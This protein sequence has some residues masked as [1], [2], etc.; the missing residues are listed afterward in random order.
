MNSRCV[1]IRKV[2]LFFWAALVS[3]AGAL[4]L[5]VTI[6]RV[7]EGAVAGESSNVL[8]N[9]Q[10]SMVSEDGRY[11]VFVST[12]ANLFAGQNDN[13]SASDVFLFDRVTGTISLVSHLAGQPNTSVNGASFSPS[14]SADGNFVVFSTDATNFGA[15]DTN[16]K[17]DI[18]L[19]SRLSDTVQVCSH[20]G[21][22]VITAS[23]GNCP[24]PASV[25]GDGTFVLFACDGTNLG[26]TDT[27][28]QQDL[29]LFNS[30]TAALTLVSHKAGNST[31]AMDIGL[32]SVVSSISKD[33][34]YVAFDTTAT[35]LGFT[36]GGGVSY[37]VLYDRVGDSFQLVSRNSAS[38]TTIA[39]DDSYR[40]LV[41]DDGS[42][43]LFFSDG[44]DLGFTDSNAAADLFIFDRGAG[45]VQLASR[46]GVSATTTA[47]QGVDFAHAALSGDGNVAVFLTGSTDMGFSDGNGG[48][49]CVIFDRTVGT[50]GLASHS[51]LGNTFTANGVCI[52]TLSVNQD[53]SRVAFSCN[54]TNLGFTDSNGQRD[55]F[56]YA[57]ASHAVTLVSHKLGDSTTTANDDAQPANLCISA[58]GKFLAF[59]SVATDLVGG[60]NNGVQDVFLATLSAPSPVVA[61]GADVTEGLAP[62]DVQ[63]Q[64]TGTTTTD[65]SN[66]VTYH[67]DPG[68]GSGVTDVSAP[69]DTLDVTY[70][71]PGIYAAKLSVTTDAGATSDPMPLVIVAGNDEVGDVD[72]EVVSMKVT[73]DHAKAAQGVQNDKLTLSGRFNP[74]GLPDDVSLVDVALTVNDDDLDQLVLNST[75]PA[76]RI[77]KTL[78][79]TGQFK[80]AVGGIRL[81]PT[82]GRRS[83]D[84]G[85]E[86]RIVKVAVN[87]PGATTPDASTAIDTEFVSTPGKKASGGFSFAKRQ[88]RNGVFQSEKTQASEGKSLGYTV[89]AKGKALA[90]FAAP[91]D[92]NGDVTVTVGGV[93]IVVPVDAFV[94]TGDTPETRMVKFSSKLADS[95][96]NAVIKSLTISNAK[97]TF[98]LVTQEV[99]GTGIP[100]SSTGTLSH[101]LPFTLE[102][103]TA[104]G[105]LVY[106]TNVELKRKA[107]SKKWAR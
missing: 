68:D 100:A 76:A 55:T 80:I 85:T 81:G 26:F 20:V 65:G 95:S 60:D 45:T 41:S 42:Y 15:T 88:P 67:F 59:A 31:T 104:S 49:D 1:I 22:D 52:G 62:L 28:T 107:G 17:T 105:V 74:A 56:I 58:D 27:N 94:I 53:G 90:E 6:E 71:T 51:T 86:P 38:S 33:G 30:G 87:V 5:D 103:T 96:V 29:F 61:F 91:A 97:K 24:F 35:D 46:T 11:T 43:V 39:N 66:I 32:Q 92:P 77:K 18:L 54:G 101:T 93:T 89:S 21:G 25:S 83:D 8:G 2:A 79:P 106:K 37:V 82:V 44:T 9:F 4:A 75:N 70:N 78:K 73:V 98:S 34:N 48:L 13:N 10:P 50:L 14:I 102:V 72:L 47:N 12:A 84:S 64:G 40:P 99:V 63:L 36:T 69:G 3:G 7:T 23:N 19:Y 16:N 57:P